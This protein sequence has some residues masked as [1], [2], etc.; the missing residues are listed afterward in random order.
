M[1]DHKFSKSDKIK[2][3][4]DFYKC[5]PK[6]NGILGFMLFEYNIQ[7]GKL[8]LNLES[9]SQYRW[10]LVM[11]VWK[12]KLN[13]RKH[14]FFFLIK[15]LFIKSYI[16]LVIF[17]SFPSWVENNQIKLD[18]RYFRIKSSIDLSGLLYKVTKI[19]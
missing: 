15:T 18:R 7:D 2:I 8:P 17:L 1:K 14:C 16:V 6:F 10:W 9:F 4:F 3:S 5:D 19:L 13:F 11:I 12:Q